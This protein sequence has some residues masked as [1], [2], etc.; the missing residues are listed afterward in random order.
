MA[1]L[2]LA[3]ELWAA[4]VE[5]LPPKWRMVCSAALAARVCA[6]VLA[7]AR[8]RVLERVLEKVLVLES[9]I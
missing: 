6:L 4:V 3:I 8:A 5:A 1:C 2:I 9:F 7:T